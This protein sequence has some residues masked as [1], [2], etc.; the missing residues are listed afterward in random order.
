MNASVNAHP[1][2]NDTPEE[3][4]KESAYA[5]DGTQIVEKA[6]EQERLSLAAE[7]INMAAKFSDVADVTLLSKYLGGD[8]DKFFLVSD[9]FNDL[10]RVCALIRDDALLPEVKNY[11]HKQIVNYISNGRV[12]RFVEAHQQMFPELCRLTRC[13]R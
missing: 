13:N 1:I 12:R 5:S 11:A 8:M 2:V 10:E 6:L 4:F 3:T 9:V 7:E